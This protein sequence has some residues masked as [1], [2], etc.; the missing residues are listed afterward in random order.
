MPTA[1]RFDDTQTRELRGRVVSLARTARA[2][3]AANQP[4]IDHEVYIKYFRLPLFQRYVAN[5]QLNSSC[6]PFWGG[7]RAVF[8]SSI[9]AHQLDA[10]AHIRALPALPVLGLGVVRFTARIDAP[11]L[12]MAS[13]ASS[14][15]SAP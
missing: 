3:P 8:T 4:D 7:I 2:D 9:L 11:P 13:A 15:A 14:L 1:A 12:S 6:H 5:V 10:A